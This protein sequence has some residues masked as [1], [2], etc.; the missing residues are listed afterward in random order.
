MAY[1][2][3]IDVDGNTKTNENVIRR[4][5]VLKESEPFDSSKMKRSRERLYNL[6]FFEDVSYDTLPG[7]K[8]GRQIV[9]FKVKERP[10]AMAQI[11]AGYSSLDGLTGYIQITENNLFG[12]GQRISILWEFGEK[13]GITN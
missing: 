6:G 11:G 1:V 8:E 13:R 7:A 4:E 9:V 10:T 12:N 2:E 5:L 3:R